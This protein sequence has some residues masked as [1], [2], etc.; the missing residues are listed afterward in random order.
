[1]NQKLNTTVKILIGESL[2]IDD[3]NVLSLLYMPIIGNRAYTLYM[4]F[5]SA[6]N[7]SSNTRVVK[8]SDITDLFGI[9]INTLTIERKKLEAI[10]L[11][12][13][14]Y[15]ENEYVYLLKAPLSARS[16][17]KDGVLAIYLKNRVGETLFEKLVSIFKLE[18]FNKEGYEN[19]TDLFDNVFKD[20]I[21]GEIDNIDGYFPDKNINSSIKIGEYKFDYDLFISSLKLTIDQKRSLTAE[22]QTNIEKTAYAYNFNEEDMQVVYHR[23]FDQNG[24]FS[25]AKFQREAKLLKKLKEQDNRETSSLKGIEKLK[26][27]TPKEV[28]K[29]VNP[30]ALPKDYNIM[31]KVATYSPFDMGITNVI[32]LHVLNKNN[33]VCPE[34]GY[35]VKTFNTFEN[36]KITTFEEAVEFITNQANYE[37]KDEVKEVIKE[38]KKESKTTTSGSDWWD[39]FKKSL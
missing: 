36:K 6:L 15:K 12:N 3:L 23:S 16:F 25:I 1:M 5:Y 18:S 37:K 39:N 32:V 29:I 24:N 31:E 7:R 4:T 13:T 2:S 17:F 26:V 34:Y 10:G 30:K 38:D 27:M 14:Y 11:L 21:D 19:V 35:F 22:M 20:K 28:L 9:T 8:L 33:K